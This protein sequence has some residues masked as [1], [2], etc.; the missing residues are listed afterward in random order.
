MNVVCS[1]TACPH[2]KGNFCTK[3]FVMINEFA[4]CDEFWANNGTPRPKPLFVIDTE[5]KDYFKNKEKEITDDIKESE[6]E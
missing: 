1:S 4:Q 6:G 3:N 2:K 5:C